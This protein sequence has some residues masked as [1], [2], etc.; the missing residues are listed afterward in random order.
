MEYEQHTWEWYSYLGEHIGT[1]RTLPAQPGN[2]VK[3]LR[4]HECSKCLRDLTWDPV[5]YVGDEA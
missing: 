1:G 3:A 5:D 4:G 2:L